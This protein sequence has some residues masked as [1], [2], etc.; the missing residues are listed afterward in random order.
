VLAVR[1]ILVDIPLR[2]YGVVWQHR[3]SGGQPWELRFSRLDHDGAVGANPP[4][5][6]PPVP[7]SD[8]KVVSA[9]VGGWPADTDAIEPQLVSTFT[10][11]P[12]ANPPSPLPPGTRL[13]TWSAGYGLAWLGRPAGGGSRT[14]YFTA[15]DENGARAVVA[16]PPPNPPAPAPITQVSRAGVDVQ[17]FALVWN[18]RTFRLAWTEVEGHVVRHVQTALTRHGSRVVHDEPSAALLRATLV[19][20][21]TNLLRT[22]LPNLDQPAPGLTSGYGWAREPARVPVAVA[23]G[24]LRR[25]RRRRPRARPVRAVSHHGAPWHRSA[26]R[27]PHLVG[28]TRSEPHR[29][30][31]PADHVSGGCRRIAGN[32]ALRAVIATAVAGSRALQVVVMSTSRQTITRMAAPPTSTGTPMWRSRAS[33]SRSSGTPAAARRSAASSSNDSASGAMKTQAV[34]SNGWAGVRVEHQATSPLRFA[35]P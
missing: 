10:H 4:R 12:W 32:A 26:A 11:D 33:S 2:E 16:Q 21:A 8:L 1:P 17:E 30:A 23:T 25:P 7:S 27:H 24:D 29:P 28:R 35:K 3:A 9:G 22:N 5:P 20:G 18:G 19:N 15:L 14:L 31:Q 6:A 13:P 34:R